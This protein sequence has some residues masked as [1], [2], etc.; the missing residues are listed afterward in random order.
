MAYIANKPV[1]FDRNYAVGEVIPDAVIEPTMTRKLVEMGRIISVD[2]PT[3]GGNAENA[4]VPPPDGAGSGAEGE[5]GTNTQ[6]EA[7]APAEGAED[8][9]EGK[10]DDEPDPENDQLTAADLINGT[11]G[12]FVC[13]VCGRAFQSPQGLAA[14]SRSHKG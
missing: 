6:E 5:G 1:R 2:I 3:T 10:G 11:A 9:A 13:E 7:E 14:H 12:E 8:G 4:P